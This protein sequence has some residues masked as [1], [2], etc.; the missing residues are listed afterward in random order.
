MTQPMLR[1]AAS[2][3][4]APADAVLRYFQQYVDCK[5]VDQADHFVRWLKAEGFTVSPIRTPEQ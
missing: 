2:N 4:N 3:P 5:P 1:L